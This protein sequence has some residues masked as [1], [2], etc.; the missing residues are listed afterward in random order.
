ML[1]LNKKNKEA[2]K[3]S[4]GVAVAFCVLVV[5]ILL[6]NDKNE[7]LLTA[8]VISFCTGLFTGLGTT[9]YTDEEE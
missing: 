3:S 6:L 1:K 5:G 2:V 9:V 4:L 7:Y 8:G